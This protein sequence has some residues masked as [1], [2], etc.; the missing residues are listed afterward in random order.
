MLIN[1]E[2]FKGIDKGFFVYIYQN[3]INGK[4]YV[5]ATTS[6]KRRLKSHRN[7]DGSTLAFH[8]SIKKYNWGNFKLLNLIKLNSFEEMLL[9]E[10]E[11]IKNLGTFGEWGYN[12]TLGGEGSFG[13]K[14]TEE[15]LKKMRAS[16]KHTKPTEEQNRLSSERTKDKTYEEIHGEEKAK[17]I[18]EL[19]S[20]NSLGENNNMYGKSLID[21]WT[22]KYGYEEAIKKEEQRNMKHSNSI[23]NIKR[24]EHSKKMK[25]RKQSKETIQANKD[26]WTDERRQETSI[27]YSGENNPMYGKSV[28][29]IWI[30]KYGIEEADKRKK[31]MLEKQEKKRTLN[32]LKK[33]NKNEGDL[34][35]NM[36]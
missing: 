32:K 17:E 28:Y 19:L 11:M 2:L 8:G 5:G 7:A 4:M 25:D 30:E 14:N 21:V 13:R 27:K 15:T 35:C 9:K 36:K 18:K 3:Q 29:S 23:T 20:K 16:N 1:Q 12:L 33:L 26:S 34:I 24:P 6:F 22:E 10:I 31:E